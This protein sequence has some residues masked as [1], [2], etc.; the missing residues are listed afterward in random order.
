[1]GTILSDWIEEMLWMPRLHSRAQDRAFCL[2]LVETMAV[3]AVQPDHQVLGFLAQEGAEVPALYLAPAARGRG[4]GK[5]LLDEAKA[6]NDGCLGLWTFQA[7]TGAIR[8]Y[9]REGFSE[10]AR[11]DGSGND[12]KLPDLRLEWR[13]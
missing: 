3:W 12:E 5:A 10:V 1:M 11:T 6:A 13:V 7:N 8:F 2:H 9:S 4:L